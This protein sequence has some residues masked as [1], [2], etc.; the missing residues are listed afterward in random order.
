M[1]HTE[2]ISPNSAVRCPSIQAPANG[3]VRPDVCKLRFGAQHRTG[4]VFTCNTSNGYQ[5]KGSRYV[6][7]LSNGTWS[8]DT[9]KT[10][11]KGKWFSYLLT[12][13]PATE[14][15]TNYWYLLPRNFINQ[16]NEGF[17]TFKKRLMHARR[18]ARALSYFCRPQKCIMFL[19]NL[20]NHL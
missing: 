19:Q 14:N 5:L 1:L 18:W 15:L 11:C 17:F 6:S 16:L 20:G 4:C 13:L 12:I 9:K 3:D 10:F 8:A 7:C 2:N